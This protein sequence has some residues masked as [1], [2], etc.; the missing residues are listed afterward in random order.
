MA[1]DTESEQPLV[2]VESQ[3]PCEAAQ[4]EPSWTLACLWA[5]IA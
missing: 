4:R 3:E 5:E 2:D 1:S